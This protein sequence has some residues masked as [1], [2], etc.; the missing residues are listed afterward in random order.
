MPSKLTIL[1]VGVDNGSAKDPD[2]NLKAEYK[3]IEQAYRESDIFRCTPPRVDIRRL[4]FSNWN[5]VMMEIRKEQPTI[6]HFG[7]HARQGSGFELF[8][9]T[10]KPRQILDAISS[11]NR[12]ARGRTPPRPDIR[13]IVLNACESDIHALDLTACVDFAIGHQRPVFDKDA[14]E[15]SLV[16][17]DSIFDGATLLDSFHMAKGCADGY[18]LGGQRDPRDF[19]L[20]APDNRLM[21]PTRVGTADSVALELLTTSELNAAHCNELIRFL[22]GKGLTSV[23]QQFS[24]HMGMELM[25]DLARLREEDLDDPEFSFLRRWQREKLME[26]VRDSTAHALSVKDTPSD[27][28][29]SGADTESDRG[30]SSESVDDEDVLVAVKH[31]RNPEEFQEHMKGFISDF[32]DYLWLIAVEIDET[33]ETFS[34]SPGLSQGRWTFCMLMWMR[35][36]K[37]AYFDEFSLS[38]WLEEC[39]CLPNQEKLLARLDSCLRLKGI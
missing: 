23:A 8:R 9:E 31:P 21:P 32:L 25:A 15:F 36:A 11:W 17:Y 35:I 26:L 33:T 3:N 4:Y 24:E 28:Y 2:L 30:Y 27:S 16:I 7:C 38:K 1:F 6:L 18:S 13:L 10:V 12:D 37:D 14:A 20:L 34:P 29:L 19:R 39:Q 22:Q 5:E